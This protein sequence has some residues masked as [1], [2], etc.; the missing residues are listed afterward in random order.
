MHVSWNMQKWNNTKRI[1]ELLT[2]LKILIAP[3]YKISLKCSFKYWFFCHFI[4]RLLYKMIVTHS[5]A[6]NPSATKSHLI[7]TNGNSLLAHQLLTPHICFCFCFFN[8]IGTSLWSLTWSRFVRS[9][10][11]SSPWSWRRDWRSCLKL[12]LGSERAAAQLN[13]RRSFTVVSLAV[14]KESRRRQRTVCAP[15]C[16]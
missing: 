15:S 9:A 1:T 7:V 4:I 10:M 11:K 16:N 2:N 3:L 12:W 5:Y 14:F 6:T 8:S 13:R